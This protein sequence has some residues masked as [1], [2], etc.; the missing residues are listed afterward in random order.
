V[1]PRLAVLLIAGCASAAE[2][3]PLPWQHA[4]LVELFTSQGCSSCPPADALVRDLPR[5]GLGRDKVVPLTFHVDYWDGLG[6]K[7]PFA[8][9]AFTER[10]SRYGHSARL[11]SPGANGPSGLYTPQMVLDGG[12]HFSGARR[13]LA[14]AELR[15]AGAAPAL[16]VLSAE[17]RAE[18]DM[19]TVTVKLTP[20]R[21]WRGGAE[22]R[23]RAALALRSAQTSVR[24]GENG[25]E[26]LEEAAIVRALSPPAPLSAPRVSVRK[27]AEVRWADTELA[28]FVQSEETLEVAAALALPAPGATP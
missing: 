10:Q 7:D 15:R 23:V 9:P 28:V 21:G 14:L 8:S 5:L 22:W 3:A 20:Q 18:G 26:R 16:L 2:S 6:W 11:R 17:A 25:G 4:V 12:V 19:A 1:G 13:E 24:S 27:P